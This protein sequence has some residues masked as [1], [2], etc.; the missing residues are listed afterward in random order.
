MGP[1]KGKQTGEKQLVSHATLAL[2]EGDVVLADRCFSGWFDLALLAQRGVDVV[3]RKHQLRA[4]DFRTGKRLGKDDH[5]VR[6][7]KPQR[8]EWLSAE[9]YEAYPPN[10]SCA[11]CAFH[12]KQR[13]FRSQRLVV[14][15]TLVNPKIFQP[16]RSQSFTV[17]AGKRSSTCEVSKSCC[18]WI[19]SAAKRRTACGTSFTCTCWPT[20]WSVA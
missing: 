16:T 15:T 14:V 19:T 4:S 7:A 2:W 13:G 9:R 1:Y 6:L 10:W 17:V 3:V 12:V 18:K 8:P 5:L 20:T 11:K